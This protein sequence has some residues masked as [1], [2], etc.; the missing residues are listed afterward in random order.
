[1]DYNW[2]EIFDYHQETGALIWKV[3]PLSHFKRSRTCL[4]VNNRFAGTHVKASGSYG[5]YRA[6]VNGRSY[7]AHRIIWEM[8]RGSIPTGIEIDHINGNPGDNRLCNLRLALHSEN[9]RNMK[10][11]KDNK[12]GV[13]GVFKHQGKYRSRIMLSGIMH[14]LGCFEDIEA[15][16]SA[17]DNA[18]KVLHGKFARLP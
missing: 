18:A 4:A 5:Y 8:H 16:R 2:S 12:L 7:K 15:A 11:H 9:M 10:T 17:Y 14:D 3:R 6:F 1:M 13:K